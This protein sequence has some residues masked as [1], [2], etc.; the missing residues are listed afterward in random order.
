[1]DDPIYNIE[2]II[3]LLLLG[4]VVSMVG[5][6]FFMFVMSLLEE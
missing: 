5:F 4:G 6:V 3:A 2:L 1:L